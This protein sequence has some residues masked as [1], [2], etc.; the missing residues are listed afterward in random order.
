[1]FAK[2]CPLGIFGSAG[3]VRLALFD[4]RCSTGTV[5]LALA[6]LLEHAREHGACVQVEV[7]ALQLRD[8]Q[9]VL[10]H[11]HA[12]D[13]TGQSA[14]SRTGHNVQIAESQESLRSQRFEAARAGG[15]VREESE[16]KSGK[17]EKWVVSSRAPG[18]AAPAAPSRASPAVLHIRCY[19]FGVIASAPLTHIIVTGPSG[20]EPRLLRGLKKGY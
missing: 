17:R 8:D 14:R 2:R 18:R 19:T 3:A 7:D 1:M 16:R 11:L 10:A 9:Q 20:V 4:W 13:R 12:R 5:R 15:G 6:R